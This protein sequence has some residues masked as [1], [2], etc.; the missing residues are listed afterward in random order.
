MRAYRSLIRRATSRNRDAVPVTV[1]L[2]AAGTAI[3]AR[4]SDQN[5]GLAVITGVAVTISIRDNVHLVWVLV[6]VLSRGLLG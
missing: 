5:W 4:A 3:I 2:V 6:V 1:G